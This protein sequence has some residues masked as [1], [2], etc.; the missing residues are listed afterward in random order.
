M[1]QGEE[2]SSEYSIANI[3]AARDD[4]FLHRRNDEVYIFLSGT[5]CRL[6]PCQCGRHLESLSPHCEPVQQRDENSAQH[7]WPGIIHGK[8]RNGPDCWEREKNNNINQ[9]E[10]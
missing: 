9:V 5:I 8:P 10:N 4:L 7:D 6:K 2:F 3:E 1:F